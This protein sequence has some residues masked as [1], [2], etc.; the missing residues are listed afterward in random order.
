VT[1]EA[2]GRFWDC[3][4]HDSRFDLPVKVLDG[5]AV[6][7]LASVGSFPVDPRVRRAADG[8]AM[9]NSAPYKSSRDREVDI[10]NGISR[11]IRLIEIHEQRWFPDQIRDGVTDALQF[12]L[13]ISGIYR[14]IE[15]SL[16]RAFRACGTRRV[17]DLCSGGSGPWLWLC[18]AL[19]DRYGRTV[20]VCLTDKYPNNSAFE[21]VHQVTQ[22]CITY[23]P[24]SVDATTVPYELLGFRTIFSSFHHF[25]RNEAVDILQ[26]AVDHQ[27]GIGVF[28]AAR[29][30]PVT[31]LLTSLMFVG[32]FL[33]AP[34]IRPFRASRLFWT[35]L[36]PVIPSVL[37][38]DGIVSCLRAYSPR[39]LSEMI[40]S[41]KAEGYAW[42]VGEEKAR[43][44]TVTYML[45][46]PTKEGS[47]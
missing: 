36:I 19:R 23:F 17:V 7:P 42:E 13:R 4:R 26:N 16:N 27:Q 47:Q 2:N 24:K 28:E 33:T 5:L 29:R 31:I 37:F 1:R 30:H 11:G 34:F 45:G 46:W 9:T 25:S 39:E 14:P 3:P 32:G 41:L 43:L 35:Y 12:I 21:H 38:F 22:G 18:Q 10:R 44:V 6:S 15:S 20:E 8:R 40:D